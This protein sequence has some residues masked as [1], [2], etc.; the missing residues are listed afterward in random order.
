MSLTLRAQQQDDLPGI[1]ALN[2]QAFTEHGETAAFDTF[3][4]ERDD[5]LSLVAV[6]NRKLVGHILFS[7]VTLEL[8]DKTLQAMGLAQLA[9]APNRQREGIGKRLVSEGI[10]W[11]RGT[12]CPL[13]VVIGHASY[14]PR[15][16]F[17]R[18]SEYGLRC[19]WSGI[20]DET[21]MIMQL[22]DRLGTELTGVAIF[23]G[24]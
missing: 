9:I 11:L 1:C 8:Q 21:F 10:E 7:P 17:V 19:Q 3:R 14:Y 23:D 4:A 5:I 20:P 15:F 18:A 22:N 2:Q 6:D 12:G 24:L 13:V 16:G